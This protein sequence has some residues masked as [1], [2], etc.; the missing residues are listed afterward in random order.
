MPV[1][2]LAEEGDRGQ[3][4]IDGQQRLTSFFRFL[5]G[6]FALLDLQSR[7]NLNRKRFRD[8]SESEQDRVFGS[9]IRTITILRQSRASIRFEM[10]H[11]YRF[12]LSPAQR[13]GTSELHLPWTVQ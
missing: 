9:E 7:K 3:V 1:I 12:G 4:V 11:T 2:Y 10:F 13:S 8:L 6:E 5:D